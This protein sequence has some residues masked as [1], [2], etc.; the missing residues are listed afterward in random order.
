MGERV[1]RTA[2]RLSAA[3]PAH[4]LPD[5]LAGKRDRRTADLK[6]EPTRMMR[7]PRIMSAIQPNGISE[8][9]APLTPVYGTPIDHPG[10]WKVADFETPADYTIELGVVHLPDIERAMRQ[11]KAAGLGLDDLRREHFDFPSL[12]PVIDEIRHE[13]EDGRG[14]VV[15]RR[16]P[17][18]DYS[19]D[20]IGMIFW[21]IGTYLGRGCRRRY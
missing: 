6:H 9:D 14:F 20:E 18:E 4:K 12:R 1:N 7:E 10:A 13:I 16:L 15:L 19:K 21:G 2:M 5:S 3:L 17:V 11:I 8:D